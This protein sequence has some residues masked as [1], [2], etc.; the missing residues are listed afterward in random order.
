MALPTDVFPAF[1]QLLAF[2][3]DDYLTDPDYPI[4]AYF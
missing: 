1:D 3:A 2:T 4:K